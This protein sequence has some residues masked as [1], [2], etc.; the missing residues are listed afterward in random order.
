MSLDLGTPKVL[1]LV[2]KLKQYP[3]LSREIRQR[4]RDEIFRRGII[5][6]AD[7][8]REV[9]KKARESQ[10]REGLHDPLAEERVDVWEQRISLIRDDLTDFY[11]AHNCPPSLLEQIVQEVVNPRTPDED[12]VLSFNPEL[13]P[14]AMLFARG[15]EYES[16]P[17][18]QRARVQHHLKEMVVVLTKGMLSDQLDFVGLAR[19]FLTISDLKAI[20]QRRIG[21]GKIGGKAAGMMLAWKII[22]RYGAEID[23]ELAA[24]VVIPESFFVGADVFYDFQ[25]INDLVRFMNQ[26]YKK[27]DAIRAEYPALRRAYVG[28]EFPEDVKESFRSLL[29][30]V[31]ASPIVVRS[32]SLLEDNFGFSFAGKYDSI[33]LPNQ[34]TPGQNLESLMHAISEVYGSTLS[35]DAL[36][37]RRRM[38]LLDYDERMAVLIQKVV[39]SRYKRYYL[40]ALAGVAFSHNPFRWNARIRREEGLVRLVWGLGTRAV[41]RV[42][43]EY[44][45][46]IALSHPTLRPEMG[47]QEVS[48]YSQHLVDVLDLTGNRLETL[49]TYD[50]LSSSYPGL[51][52]IASVNKGD[53]VQPLFSLLDEPDPHTL[54]LTFDNLIANTNFVPLMKFV[55]TTLEQHYQRPVDI[56]FAVERLGGPNSRELTLSLLQC[57]PLSL[58]QNGQP[59]E[60]PEQVPREDVLFMANRLVP[61]GVVSGIKYIVWIDPS[62]YDRIPDPVHKTQVARTVGQLNQ[63]LEGEKFVLMGPGRWGSSNVSLGVKISYADIDHAS[64]LIEVALAHGEH[65]P[66]ASYGTHFFQD[67][68][69]S[70]IYPLPIYPDDPQTA[71]AWAFFDRAPNVLTRI[72]PGHTNSDTVKVIDIPEVT[73]GRHLEIVMDGE[74]ERALGYLK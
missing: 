74:Q 23:P 21:R 61:H 39:G 27:L 17:P 55:L 66:E 36:E 19:E 62:A 18:E 70:G 3:I 59:V 57:R 14:W 47:V 6:P 35:P 60:I 51:H 4:M 2:L 29:A 72:L 32:S 56:E 54:V 44:P 7:F 69:E 43:K 11:F 68:V 8:E 52:L 33:F 24:H 26:K 38:G 5:T 58:Q 30:E 12:F 50:L 25:A 64:V 71:F 10:I 31:G 16:Y 63:A 48:K 15:E 9:R 28:G 53:Y 34:G 40:P 73:G 67:L 13:A 45:R 46:M 42:S 65:A 22:Q 20:R 49:P 41:D 37:Y 1:E